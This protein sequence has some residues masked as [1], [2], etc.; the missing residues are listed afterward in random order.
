MTDEQGRDAKPA[1]LEVKIGADVH[2][3]LEGDPA[4]VM[5]AYR[6]VREDVAAAAAASSPAASSSQ[7]AAP[8]VDQKADL[9]PASRRVLW[10]YR[11]DDEMRTVYATE[12]ASYAA[13]TFAK[14]FQ[15]G[16]IDRVYVE[17]DRILRALRHGARTLWR[18]L[19]PDA[20]EKIKA[21]GERADAKKG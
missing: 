12:R 18:E 3:V 6:Q 2:V 4:F 13:S 8:V 19:G 9:P 5:E 16:K 14:R 17:D 11:C 7:E 15:L 21:A 10:L 1:R 20:A